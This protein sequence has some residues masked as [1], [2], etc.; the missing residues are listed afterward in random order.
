MNT[1]QEQEFIKNLMSS[2]VK[3][4][5]FPAILQIGGIEKRSGMIIEA[6]LNSVIGNNSIVVNEYHHIDYAV[7]DKNSLGKS[8]LNLSDLIEVKSNFSSQLADI[9]KRLPKGI[10]Q[11]KGY[12]EL[13]NS[14]GAG[15]KSCTYVL[16]IIAAP[17]SESHPMVPKDAGFIYWK[18]NIV[19]AK[20]SMLN[21][22]EK[23][24]QSLLASNANIVS[25]SD[26]AVD[27]CA[28]MYI[29]LIKI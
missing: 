29:A 26:G 25:D 1:R 14:F 19:D 7:A 2:I 23:L 22:K 11:V 3:W 9:S 12:Q 16:Y 28:L 10:A 5:S 13:S 20:Q 21:A 8:R 4:S 24:K 6:A 27:D 15:F 17:F 18:K